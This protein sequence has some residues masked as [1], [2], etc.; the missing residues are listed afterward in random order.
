MKG[1]YLFLP[2]QE[3]NKM[4]KILIVVAVVMSAFV[5]HYGDGTTAN[6]GWT[7]VG[8]GGFETRGTVGWFTCTDQC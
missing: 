2:Y 3:G 8:V 1:P 6:E 7:V 4:K 5:T